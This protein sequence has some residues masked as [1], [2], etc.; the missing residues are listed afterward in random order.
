MTGYRLARKSE[1]QRRARELEYFNQWRGSESKHIAR[2]EDM[3]KYKK[4]IK[5][6][7]KFAEYSYQDWKNMVENLGS[8]SEELES[9][10][11]V[12]ENIIQLDKEIKERKNKKQLM[13][14]VDTVK[15]QAKGQGWSQEQ[16]VDAIRKELFG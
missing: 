11:Y 3:K 6:H 1:L 10:G 13:D 2:T 15:S 12:S 5:N 4:F 9:Y 8:M 7:P 14:V 16:L